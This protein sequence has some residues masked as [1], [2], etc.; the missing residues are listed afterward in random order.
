MDCT[1]KLMAKENKEKETTMSYYT[2][3]KEYIANLYVMRCFAVTMGVYTVAF[4]LNQLGIFVIDKQLMKMGYFPSILIYLTV[5]LISKRMSPSSKRTKYVILFSSVL[6]FSIIG[7]SITYHVVLISLL[8]FLYATLYSSKGVLRYVYF[9]TVISTILIVYGGYFFGLCDAN[10]AL[11]TTGTLKEHS[12]DGQF[13][14]TQVNDNPMFNLMLYYVVPRC[15]IYVAFMS[16]CTSIF[17]ILNESLEKVK[18]MDELEQAKEAAEEANRAK[19]QFI[20]R[21]SHEIRT[22]INAIM[23]MN[24]MIMRESR[25][26]DIIQYADDVRNS[27]TILLGII[28]ELLDAA[29]I[30]SGKM[31]VL[32]VEYDM[33]SFLND[34]YHL[35]YI[36]A[37]EKNLTLNFE[38]EKTIP[39]VYFG[40]DKRIRQVLINLLTNS[41]KYTDKGEVTLSLTAETEGDTAFLHFSVRDT[42]IGIKKE[43]LESICEEFKRADMKRNRS[44]EGTGLGMNIVQQLLRLMGSELKIESEYEKGS[45]FQF[46]LEQKIVDKSPL[47]DFTASFSKVGEEKFFRSSFVAPDARILVV[48]D[49]PMNIKVLKNLLKQNKVQIEGVESGRECLRLL[50]QQSFDLI[51]LDHRMPGMDGVETLHEMRK[52]ELGK[53]VPVIML[54]ANAIVGDREKYLEEGFDEFLSKPIMPE[55]LEKIMLQFLPEKYIQTANREPEEIVYMDA[56]AYLES[57]EK[58]DEVDFEQV[59]EVFPEFNYEKALS[60]C[61]GEEGFYL[62]LL[63]DFTELTI[64]TE[65][66]GYVETQ[67]SENYS[68]R[69]HGFKNNAYS[70]G[71]DKLGDLAYKMEQESKNGI[72]EALIKK[73]E[74]LFGMYA[75]ICE[76]YRSLL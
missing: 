17:K 24:E 50:R 45:V 8:P 36:R 75:Q 2:R 39:K 44:V 67:D 5:Y 32:P 31:E 61:N 56:K 59:K 23:G 26:C 71:A 72:T 30:E 48:D 20:A 40:D 70:V 14:L 64:K 16:V 73:Q 7:V 54:T 34:L 33:G 35:I 68:I 63:R 43:E 46:V 3:D 52:Q 62:E 42:G 53:G 18:L 21:V 65:L 9:L 66:E 4:L 22:P 12:V 69:I 60:L 55:R 28:N 51:F 74:E 25:E 19:T 11:L 49:Y 27:S 47:G 38:I 6:V 10:M 58:D 57:L 15:L 37:R 76:T 1:V 29:K 13:I 41:V